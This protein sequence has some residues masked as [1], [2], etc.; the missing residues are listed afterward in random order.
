VHPPAVKSVEDRSIALPSVVGDEDRTAFFAPSDVLCVR[1]LECRRPRSA[2]SVHVYAHGAHRVSH[3][4]GEALNN[5]DGRRGIR[6][7]QQMARDLAATAHQGIAILGTSHPNKGAT[8]AADKVLGSKAWRS[9]PRSVMLFGRDP[10][11]PDGPS[12]VVAVSKGNYA[13][14]KP[15]RRVRIDSV[16]VAGVAG[17][18][19]RAVI[20]DESAYTDQ[21]LI[22]QA[23]GRTVSVPTS[24]GKQA[25]H[26]LY[27]LL[28]D[29]GG[30]VEAS[31]AYAAA[32]AA[33]ISEKTMRRAREKVGA[34]A[35]RVWA[36]A[37]RMDM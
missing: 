2:D 17:T 33:G 10:D 30:K 28:E 25:E 20:G 7:L 27:R 29:G 15:S 16:E 5:G 19:P 36:L 21:D 24:K 13:A 22:A 9:V 32:E 31:A 34:T 6:P 18:L 4:G 12:R 14:G 37:E 26:L 23:G 1:R 35:G 11:D 8:N 3:D